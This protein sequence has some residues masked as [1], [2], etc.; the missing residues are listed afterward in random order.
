MKPLQVFLWPFVLLSPLLLCSCQK[1]VSIDLNQTNP[2]VVIEGVVSN[3]QGPTIVSVALSGDYFAPSLTFP[4][5]DHALVLV[6]DNLGNLDTLREDSAGIYRSS[7]LT[8]VPG[9]TY[10]LRVVARGT[11]YDAT[12]AMPAKVKIDSLYAIPFREFDGDHSYNMYVV[13][14]DPPETQNWYRL[15]AHSTGAAIDS[16]GGR[17]FIL[18]TD[19]LTNGVETAFRIRSGR[20]ALAG[21]T[22]IVHLY[23]ISK[24]TYDY[25]NTVNAILGSDRSPTS[26][27]PANPNTNLSNGSLGY[28]AAY[29]VD[30]MS[31]I[32]PP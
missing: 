22:V 15:D 30:S 8:G 9:R 16:L 1:V 14:H 29:A 13:F 27:A 17:R 11:E 3:Q 5:V 26:L 24:A 6:A 32:L 25:Y 10:S 28:F 21:D 31:V 4:P 12:C 2:Q 7:T 23:S 18:Y 20:Q 19:R